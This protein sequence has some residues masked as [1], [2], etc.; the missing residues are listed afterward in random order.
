MRKVMVGFVVATALVA[1]GAAAA[2]P[3][4]PNVTTYTATCVGGPGSAEAVR[5]E[6]S[7]DD[8]PNSRPGVALH[9]VG[10]NQIVL[11]PDTPG[12]VARAEEEGTSCTVT[13]INGEDVPDFTSLVIFI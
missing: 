10:S 3:A 4:N 12:L 2:A 6:L 13:H 7:L 5:V 1:V 8:S 11:V 9:I